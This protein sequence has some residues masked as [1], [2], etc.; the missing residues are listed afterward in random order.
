[1]ATWVTPPIWGWED[2]DIVGADADTQHLRVVMRSE[3]AV[4]KAIGRTKE[5]ARGLIMTTV[6]TPRG[7]GPGVGEVAAGNVAQ[8]WRDFR[9]SR[10]QLDAPSVVG[11]TPDG[12]F[13]RHLVTLG[14][15][16]DMRFA[17]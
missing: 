14:W 5:E 3:G 6:H 7:S 4:R 15:R 11:L 8:L 17:A 9:H 10:I 12:A 13:N 1:M 2:D 16:G